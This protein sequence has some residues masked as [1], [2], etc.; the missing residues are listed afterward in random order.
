MA[1]YYFAISFNL[2]LFQPY[3]YNLVYQFHPYIFDLIYIANQF[4]PNPP[5]P[6]RIRQHS[7]CM[8]HVGA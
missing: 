3:Y 8:A 6:K 5:A 7:C 4:R 2:S 1:L